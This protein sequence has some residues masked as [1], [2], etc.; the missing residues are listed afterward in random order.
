M[1]N[2]AFALE[3]R[4]EAKSGC[5]ACI[6]VKQSDAAV[7]AMHLKESWKRAWDVVVGR[8]GTKERQISSERWDKG[9]NTSEWEVTERA[10]VW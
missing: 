3:R 2:L 9:G 1:R 6:Q 4:R 8:D 10:P 5:R 7:F